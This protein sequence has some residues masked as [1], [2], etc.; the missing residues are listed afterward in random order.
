MATVNRSELMNMAAGMARLPPHMHPLRSNAAAAR[1]RPHLRAHLNAIGQDPVLRG[2]ALGGPGNMFPPAPL[3]PNPG[4][5][6]TPGRQP[7]TGHVQPGQ[8]SMGRWPQVRHNVLG[9]SNGNGAAVS[10]PSSG[11]AQQI[12]ATPQ[13]PFK[14][15]RVV[16]PTFVTTVSDGTI[17]SMTVGVRPQF[18]AAGTEPFQIFNEKS[19]GGIWDMDVCEVGQKITFNATSTVTQNFYCGL[20]GE[21]MDGKPYPILSSPLRRIGLSA[22]NVT[23]LGIATITVNPQVRFRG[24]KLVIDSNS[25]GS[26]LITLFQVGIQNQFMSADPVPAACFTELAQDVWLDLDQAYVGNGITL[27]V[28]NLGTNTQN[29]T[30]ALLGDIDPRDLVRYGTRSPGVPLL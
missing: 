25:G 20:I 30:G 14:P 4:P 5:P 6:G 16:I 21:A 8:I 7:F 10:L 17:S 24:R 12:V 2:I 13:T 11:V 23:T 3:P 19:T 22:N 15:N 29:F 27:T 9:V 28:Q 26:F 1:V 18:G